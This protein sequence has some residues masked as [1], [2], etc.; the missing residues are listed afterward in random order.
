MCLCRESR[1]LFSQL[2]LLSLAD[3]DDG[4]RVSKGNVSMLRLHSSDVILSLWEEIL[5]MLPH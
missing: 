3:G 1:D 4:Q 5:Q 2:V